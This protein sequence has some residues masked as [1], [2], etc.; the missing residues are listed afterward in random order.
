MKTPAAPG[1]NEAPPAGRLFLV[2]ALACAIASAPSPAG[3]ADIVDLPEESVTASAYEDPDNARDL[4]PGAVSIVRPEADREVKSLSDLLERVPGLHVIRA[5]GRGGY[6]VA[7]VR[8][9][10]SAQVAVFVD[11]MLMNLGSESAVD[12]STI[13]ADN[14]ERIEVYRGYIPARFGAAGMGGVINIVTKGSGRGAGVVS[15]GA[16]AY[17][18]RR[19]SFSYSDSL[20]SGRYLLGGSYE[21][22]D[23]NFKYDNDNG[24]PYNPDDDY[25]ATRQYND[26]SNT[27]LLFKWD[28]ADWHARAAWVRN[29]RSLPLSAPGADRPDSPRG[30]ATDAERMEFS[31]SR[32]FRA[33]GAQGIDWG[34]RAEYLHKNT[35]FDDPE[36]TTGGY[37]EQ[38]NRYKTARVRFA[39]D[40]SVVA[41]R[42][43]FLEMYIAYAD[44]TLKQRGDI[45]SSIGGSSRIA[46]RTLEAS[47]ADSISL[48]RDGT[49][50][51]VPSLRYAGD[52]EDGELTWQVAAT[53]SLAGGFDLY[54]SGGTYARA[55]NLYE[56]YGDGAMIRPNDSLRWERGSQWELGAGWRGE[57]GSARSEARLAYFTRDSK[58]LIEFVMSSPRNGVYQNVGRAEARGVELEFSADWES[59]WRLYAAG[60]W[61][62]AFD[63]TSGSYRS[64]A[65]LPN[66]PEWDATLRLERDWN[67][68]L[69]SFVELRYT[70]EN[71]YDLAGAVKIDDLLLAN[72]GASYVFP[73]GARFALGIDDLFDRG[74]QTG[75]Y[76]SGGMSR[77]AWY[78]LQ[79]R[80]AYVNLGWAF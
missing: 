11:G 19:A 35:R 60:T 56:R 55:P 33:S 53:K 24:T 18:L 74:P 25:R 16:G 76:S 46:N 39:A 77:T 62:D 15:A 5:R 73:N 67:P 20:G 79:G 44:E 38:S 51:L 48:S 31:L 32:R 78:P 58:N 10:T 61:M 75:I 13:A 27:D 68:R 21:S 34:V 28:S 54:A 8:G 30:A 80:T 37:G 17:G 23:G 45:V 7:S 9:S 52:D 3:A 71:Y 64:D 14:V 41:G 43:H 36:D 29:E 1:G 2:C 42:D 69:S 40:A 57:L 12:I 4:S 65:P 47:L 63:K 70:G 59:G 50:I 49:L 66:R 26:Y 72:I 22:A 6:T